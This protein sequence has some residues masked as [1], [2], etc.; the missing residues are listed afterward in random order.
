MFFNLILKNSKRNRRENGLFFSSLLISIVAFYIIL[1]L[2]NQD[3]MIFLRKMESDAVIQLMNIIPVFYLMTLVILFFLIYFACKYQLNRRRHEFGIYLM[4]GMQPNRL[5]FM[6]LSEDFIGSIAALITG[7]PVA[8]LL[9]ELI[10]L[11]TAKLVGMG[12]IGHQFSI[13]GSALIFTVIGFLLIKLAAFLILSRAISRQDI[14][15]LLREI[16]V[17]MGKQQPNCLYAISLVCGVL[18][19]AT[20]Y[21]MAIRGV[22]WQNPA[23]MF[24]T[25]LIGLTGTIFLF[26]GM[27]AVITLLITKTKSR[28]KLHIFNIRQL[29]E[30][31][32]LQSTSMAISSLLILAALCLFGAGIGIAVTNR[33]TDDHLLDYT[34]SDFSTEDP[35]NIFPKIMEILKKHNLE[36]YF[37]DLFPMRLGN[38]RTT[39]EY[40]N[41]F[42]MNAVMESL[43]EMPQSEKRDILLNNLSYTDKPHIICLSDYNRLLSL[44]HKPALTINKDEAAV[45]IDSTFIDKEQEA[46]LN[47]ILSEH[48]R[49]ELDGSTIYLKGEVQTTRVVTDRSITLSFALIL[50]DDLFYYYTQNQYDVYVNGI[51]DSSVTSDVSLMN[52]ISDTNDKLNA[53]GLSDKNI[54]YESYLQNMGRQ[55]FYMVASS[56]LTIYLAVIFLVSANTI[57]GVQFLMNQQKNRRRYQILIHL[58][59]TYEILCKSAQKQIRW[60]TGLPVFV[61]TIS[62]FFGVKALFAGILSSEVGELEGK[63]LL[64][65]VAMIFLLLVVEC[66]YMHAV[67]RSSDRYLLTL[68]ELPREE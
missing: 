13:S 8:I 3:V 34:F 65:S 6:L 38:I 12:I 4:M 24:L 26:Y 19:L 41:V 29:Q 61:A 18:M 49:S 60:Y 10:S 1:S 66:L 37:S 2:S 48:P 62:S 47:Q 11:I 43:E 31:V 22:S 7:L 25:T 53:L 63:M 30:H 23:M 67:K 35:E 9:S 44:S 46:M 40:E 15:D 55:L 68:M 32:I 33:Q 57:I 52:A 51:L 50:P 20:S 21:T 5:F 42:I 36:H 58:G 14:G 27:R 54:R 64:V 56:Y 59:A 16:P 17:N 28:Q 45:Y 39:E